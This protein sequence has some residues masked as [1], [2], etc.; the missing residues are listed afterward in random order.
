MASPRPPVGTT[1]LAKPHRV[2]CCS[3][4]MEGGGSE[5]QLWQMICHLDRQRFSPHLYLLYRRGVYLE[6]LPSDVGVDAFWDSYH[7]EQFKSLPF[8][9]TQI[10]KKQIEHLHNI[11]VQNG[12]QVVYDRTFH[13]TLITAAACRRAGIP[14]ASVI[15]SPPGKDFQQSRERFRWFKKRLLAAAYR[16]RRSLTIAVS[17]AVAEDAAKFYRLPSNLIRVM[18]SPV[19]IELVRLKSQQT[20]QLPAPRGK[21]RVV[22]IGRLSSEKGHRLL[23][24]AIQRTQNVSSEKWHLDILGDGPERPH[25]ESYARQ[26]G[27]AQQVSFHGFQ[28]NP[29]PWIA[30]ASLV[31]ISSSYEGLPNVALESMAIG[32]GLVA[33]RCSESLELLIGS[34]E[35]G[36][37]VPASDP[38]ALAS[39]LIG[40]SAEQDAWNVRIRAAFEWVSKHHSIETWM[41]EIEQALA[42]LIQAHYNRNV[43]SDQTRSP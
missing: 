28:S 19:D 26:L 12:T 36:V 9:P 23:L 31:C 18:P 20:S 15:V 35:R 6:Q 41:A 33:T 7:K 30:R 22:S 43:P 11:I 34:N 8:L 1:S 39:A 5:R 37:L 25:L 13:M 2:L 24:D 16:D 27:V 42:S 40:Y 4:S 10:R 3:G 32:T 38:D 21:Q 14:R 17:Q 29:Y